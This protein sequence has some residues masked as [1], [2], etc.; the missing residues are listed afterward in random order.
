[1]SQLVYAEQGAGYE[2]KLFD[3]GNTDILSYKAE[4]AMPFGS[5]GVLGADAESV[6]LP[7]VAGDLDAVNCLGVV[8]R[9]HTVENGFDGGVSGTHKVGEVVSMIKKGRVFVKTVT[10]FNA[11]DAVYVGFQNGEEGKISNAASADRVLLANAKFI[12]SG[13]AGEL[14]VLDLALV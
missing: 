3:L 4:V 14:A 7:A 2:G 13:L 10:D 12:N 5:F 11:T 1:M 8:V 6:K 9:T